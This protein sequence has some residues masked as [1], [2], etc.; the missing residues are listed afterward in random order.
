MLDDLL[1]FVFVIHEGAEEPLEYKIKSTK[2]KRPISL[3]WLNVSIGEFRLACL[4]MSDGERKPSQSFNY[5][6]EVLY[7]S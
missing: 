3:S 1:E 6:K 4:K 2:Y 5:I 7:L